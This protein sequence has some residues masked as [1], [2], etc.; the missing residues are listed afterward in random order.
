VVSIVDQNVVVRSADDFLDRSG[1]GDSDFAQS[2][3]RRLTLRVS[4]ETVPARG[5]FVDIALDSDRTHVFDPVTGINLE[6][7]AACAAS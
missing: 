1:P 7:E 4:S 6:R 3:A 5:S 2:N